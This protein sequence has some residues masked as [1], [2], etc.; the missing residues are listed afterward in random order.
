MEIDTE[1]IPIWYQN[2]E[3]VKIMYENQEAVRDFAVTFILGNLLE[4]GVISPEDMEET[5]RRMQLDDGS[6][7][8][9]A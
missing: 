8:K 7:G 6:I 3:E 5:K 1:M 2:G 9:S 4:Q